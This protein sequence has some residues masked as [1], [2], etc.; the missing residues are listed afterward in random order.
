MTVNMRTRLYAQRR[1]RV[2]LFLPGAWDWA[3]RDDRGLLP[4]LCF[5]HL[6]NAVG[7][8]HLVH[9]K[10]CAA[11]RSDRLDGVYI[12]LVVAS[13]VKDEPAAIERMNGNKL[14]FEP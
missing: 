6:G 4:V 13:A 1:Q 3:E 5:G 10:R 2:D 9:E 12:A 11:Y 8:G 14:L 7:A